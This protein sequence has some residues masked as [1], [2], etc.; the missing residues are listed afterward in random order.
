M[1]FKVCLV[2]LISLMGMMTSIEIFG[3]DLKSMQPAPIIIF[4]SF[5]MPQTSLKL[6]MHQ[7]EII[8]APVIIRGLVNNSFKAT[9]QK[10]AELTKD[11]HGGVQIDPT[12]FRRFQINKVPA[13][14]VWNENECAPSQSCLENYDVIY[15]DVTL[16]FALK[17]IAAENDALSEIAT[18]ASSILRGAMH[19]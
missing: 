12:L 15:G 4:V 9:I 18:R 19:E 10:M 6:M 11:N 3:A 13:V 16:D 2:S 14:V 5:S 7:A 1:I 17:K 8:H